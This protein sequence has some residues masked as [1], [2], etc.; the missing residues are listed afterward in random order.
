VLRLAVEADSPTKAQ[1][2][3]HWLRQFVSV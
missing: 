3:V 1:E 2:L